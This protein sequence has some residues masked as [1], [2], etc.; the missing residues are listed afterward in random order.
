MSRRGQN[1]GHPPIDVVYL[2]VDGADPRWQAKRQRAFDE[3]LAEHPTELAVYGNV[4]GRFRDNGELR[5]NLRALERFF[6]D[7]GHVYVV[8]DAQ[9]PDWLDAM[10]GI[11]IVDHRDLIPPASLPVFDSGHIESYVHHIPGLA[12]R[13]FYLNDDIFFGAAVD[14][15]QWFG[16]QLTMAM[17]TCSVER[18]ADLQPTGTALVNA[19]KLSARWLASMYP[20]Y[21]HEWRLF[22]HS[23]RA[24]LRSAMYELERRACDL[25]REVR[26]TRFRSWRIPPIVSDLAMRWMVQTGAARSITLDPLYVSTGDDAAETQFR[27]LRS[28]FGRLAFFCINDTSDD[29]SD[30][31]RKLLRVARVLEDLLPTPSSFELR[32]GHTTR[33]SAARID[34]L[35][36]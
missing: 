1:G 32:S 27:E 31:D 36:A 13:Y 17:E 28:R 21:V 25:F 8:T 34:A 3:W 6:P 30:N 5:F 4:S 14:P 19:S 10:A 16:E 12:E 24:F 33:A 7:H 2:W 20:G 29:A 23:P 18:S 35:A 9:V 11:T 15:R 22:A 26:S